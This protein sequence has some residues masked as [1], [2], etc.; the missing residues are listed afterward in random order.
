MRNKREAMRKAG[1]PLLPT[2]HNHK[3]WKYL[4]VSLEKSLLWVW[5]SNERYDI[6]FME[7]LKMKKLIVG[8]KYKLKNGQELF[9]E[10]KDDN[11]YGDFCDLCGKELKKG[12]C[13]ADKLN[14]NPHI[15][16]IYMVPNVLKKY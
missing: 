5:I 14:G 1:E 8:N 3:S 10:Y 13:F 6:F 2:G 4:A 11:C 16:Y 15:R 7:V 9:L 12:F